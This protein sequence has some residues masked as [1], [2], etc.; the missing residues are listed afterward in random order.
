M[1]IRDRSSMAVSV[2]LES[3]MAVS[4]MAVSVELLVLASV[5]V[6][7]TVV[8]AEWAHALVD[9]FV[10]L[11]AKSVDCSLASAVD[12]LLKHHLAVAATSCED[13]IQ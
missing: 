7:V 4:L 9:V 12:V 13:A 8:V 2:E 1:C 6:L 10:V 3:L 11:L 5:W